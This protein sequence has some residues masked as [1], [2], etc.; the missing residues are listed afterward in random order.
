MSVEDGAS[1]GVTPGTYYGHGIPYLPI[2]GYPGKIIAVEGTSGRAMISHTSD[3][4]FL[5]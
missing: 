3:T 5:G 2:Q 4:V 1:A